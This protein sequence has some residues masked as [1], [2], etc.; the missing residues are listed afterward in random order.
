MEDWHREVTLLH[1]HF[2]QFG[3]RLPG[4]LKQEFSDLEAAIN[5]TRG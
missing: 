5:A 2:A 4:A 1:D 3:D